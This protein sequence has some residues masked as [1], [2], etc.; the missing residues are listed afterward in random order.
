MP[1]I[2][3][4]KDLSRIKI[5]VMFNLTKRQLICFG[6]GAVVGLPLFFILKKSLNPSVSTLIMV[7]SMLPF[8]LFA[9][10][11]KNG[12]PLEKLVRNIVFTRFIR[13]RQR[14]Y[15]TDNF[16]AAIIRHNKL[17]KGVSAIAKT[18]KDQKN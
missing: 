12:L 2:T 6:I 7:F 8:F 5:K 9:I 13:S 4:P 15:V 3:V 10:Y 16:Y 1:Y 18:S 17:E 14:P 11:E